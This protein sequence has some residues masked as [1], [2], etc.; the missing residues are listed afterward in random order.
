MHTLA[1]AGAAAAAV[2]TP[3]REVVLDRFACHTAICPASMRAFTVFSNLRTVFGGAAAL[4]GVAVVSRVASGAQS[5][6]P[7]L[8]W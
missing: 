4:A 3:Q 1:C 5:L 7:D 2:A 6:S 8:L